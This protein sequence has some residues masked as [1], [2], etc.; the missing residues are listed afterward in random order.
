MIAARDCL[1][2]A[3]AIDEQVFGS[4]HPML[5]RRLSNLARVLQKS[6]NLAGAKLHLDRASV[7]GSSRQK[8]AADSLAV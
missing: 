8:R 3:L 7:I 6:G 5:L 2:R 1:E 4:E